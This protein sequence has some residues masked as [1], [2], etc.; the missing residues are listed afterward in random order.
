VDNSGVLDFGFASQPTAMKPVAMAAQPVAKPAAQ[1]P[2]GVV[3]PKKNDAWD[4]GDGLVNLNNLNKSDNK[5]AAFDPNSK[6]TRPNHMLP[7]LNTAPQKISFT[8]FNA[9]MHPN[10]MMGGPGRMHPNQQMMGR[11]PQPPMNMGMQFSTANY[12]QRMGMP[13]QPNY[14]MQVPYGQQ[15]QFGQPLRRQL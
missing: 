12:P 13:M 11:A 5:Y 1:Q 7:H 15:P 6:S 14:G 10:Q 2:V 3:K 8:S 4:L 9:Q